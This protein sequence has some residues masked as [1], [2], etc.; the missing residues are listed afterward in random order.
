MLHSQGCRKMVLRMEPRQFARGDYKWARVLLQ[1]KIILCF[2]WFIFFKYIFNKNLESIGQ[3]QPP[4]TPPSPP[5]LL[6]LASMRN[7]M[8]RVIPCW[9]T[10]WEMLRWQHMSGDLLPF[11][12]GI[13]FI[14]KPKYNFWRRSS[15]SP[16]TEI[17]EAV[18]ARNHLIH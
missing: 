16:K 2:I 11:Q 17:A 10:S 13:S 15:S 14:F 6:R 8:L 12:C 5:R 7:S 4:P 1:V 18:E 9:R 3:W